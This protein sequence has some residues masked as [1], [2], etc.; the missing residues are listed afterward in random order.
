MS[1]RVVRSLRSIGAATAAKAE[2]MASTEASASTTTAAKAGSATTEAPA[3]AG[4]ATASSPAASDLAQ[5]THAITL[6][7]A[8]LSWAILEG[9]KTIENRTIRLRPGWYVLHTGKGKDTLQRPQ[10]DA[11]NG[12]AE[13][14]LPHGA[15]VGA[16]KVSHSLS[17]EQC[18]GDAWATGPVCNVVAATVE[19]ATPV[20]MNGAL[21]VWPLGAD[22]LASVR[23]GLAAADVRVND[24]ARFPGP[25]ESPAKFDRPERKP[26]KRARTAAPP[27]P[28]PAA[29]PAPPPPPP[30]AE[31]LA[32]RVAKLQKMV[33]GAGAAEAEAALRAA[34]FNLSK[35]TSALNRARQPAGGPS[36]QPP[37]GRVNAHL[38][39]N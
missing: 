30:S 37:G 16:L 27:V 15:V 6:K 20:P 17:L 29:A 35:A 34:G 28:A 12:P 38:R 14:S 7:G 39:F 19:L 23:A 13:A 33:R 5:V 10:L 25:A 32:S 3:S 26:A 24:V 36:P 9:H 21:G 1:E 4:G 2:A 18:G 22:A 8:R 11:L 31:E